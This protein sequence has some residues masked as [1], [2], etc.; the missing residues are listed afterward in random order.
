[1]TAA[2]LGPTLAGDGP[3][4]VFA[5]TD[6]AFAKMPAG[7]IDTLLAN[8]PKLTEVLTYH[9]VDG[10]VPASTVITMDGKSVKT[11]N[12]AEARIKV[13][14]DG[15]VEIGGAKVLT[16][17]IHCDNGVIHVIDSVLTPPSPAPVVSPD[18][19]DLLA[20]VAGGGALTASTR[21]M[22]NE[23]ILKL[24]TSNPTASPATSALL[25]GEWELVYSGG[26]SEGLFNGS[27]TRQI[28]LFL[29]AGGY[30]PATFGLALSKA[31]PSALLSVSNAKLSIRRKQP[32]VEAYA[33]VKAGPLPS[34]PVAISCNLEAQSDV[35]LKETYKAVK[36]GTSNLDVPAALQYSRLLYVVYLDED[37]LIVRD[38]TG[39]P[40]VLLRKEMEFAVAP[41]GEPSFLDDDLAPG[42][43]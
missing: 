8:V 3:F 15:T 13:N 42:A 23:L 28:A 21:V 34:S 43:G 19:S 40:E 22:V 1:M 26:Y 37:L 20:T 27:P 17:D 33:E 11:V 24:E 7:A 38:E 29:Y 32:R 30:A 18:K 4:T 39:V 10:V 9:L 12:G 16:T 41:S 5:P 35:R 6:A 31:L 25:N 36:V 14:V 2:G